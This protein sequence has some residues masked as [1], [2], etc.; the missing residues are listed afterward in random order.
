MLY[1]LLPPFLIIGAVLGYLA[2]QPG[3]LNVRR[4]LKMRCTREAASDAIRDLR[5]WR[6]WSPFLLHEPD[7]L[8]TYSDEPDA[9]EGWYDWDGKVVGA[10]RIQHIAMH[11][12]ERIEQ[13]LTFRRPFKSSSAVTW[14]FVEG[15]DDGTP[16]TEVFWTMRGRM[17]F[18]LRFLAPLMA[19]TLGKD[20]ELGLA[21]LRA[22]LD[23]EAPRL[24]IRF[25][26]DTDLPE[27]TAWTI[28]FDGGLEAMKQ[29][30]AEG[31]GRL[32][33]EAAEQGIEPTAPPLSAY[34]AVDQKTGRFQCDIA[35]PVPPGS[36][37]GDLGLK[38]FPGGRFQSLLLT[39]SYDFLDLAWH[40]AMGH[41]RM[42]KQTWDRSRPCYEIYLNDPAQVEPNALQT[43]IL[44]PL[45]G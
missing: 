13:R 9:A 11:A 14:E 20:F 44:V 28:P 22:R 3:E 42:S 8:L 19:G 38:T 5:A 1:I 27:Q 29:A 24:S 39:G 34:H 18:F 12:P 41:V 21:Q 43:R 26:P 6:E 10:G 4:S 16:V 31:F 25:E 37:G 15:E 23:A 17:P 2:L 36:E 40:A 45:K 35:L 30:M 7:A 33:S 32:A